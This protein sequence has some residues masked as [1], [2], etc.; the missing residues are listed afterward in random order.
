MKSDIPASISGCTLF[1]LKSGSLSR[2]TDHQQPH[3]IASMTTSAP[4]TTFQG[5]TGSQIDEISCGTEKKGIFIAI[6][7]SI[8]FSDNSSLD[9]MQRNVALQSLSAEELFWFPMLDSR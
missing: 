3:C 7:S 5:G 2:H 6:T 1:S 4:T 9:V 8:L